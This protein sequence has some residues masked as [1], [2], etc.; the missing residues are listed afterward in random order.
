[1]CANVLPDAYQSSD[2][3]R[4]SLGFFIVAALDILGVLHNTNEQQAVI[5]NDEHQGWID[6]IYSCQVPDGSGFRGFPGTDLAERRS[7]DNQEWDPGNLPNTFFA[8]VTLLI[9]GDKLQRVKRDDLLTWLPGLQRSDG[10]FGELM[11]SSGIEG[12]RDLR[13]CCCAAGI[14]YILQGSHDDPRHKSINQNTLIDYILNSQHE[15]GGFA[16]SPFREPHSGLSYCAVA[17][18]ELIGRSAGPGSVRARK[19][20]SE[21]HASCVRWILQRQTTVLQDE[22]YDE[23]SDPDDESEK[24]DRSSNHPFS[25]SA[26]FYTEPTLVLGFNGRDNKIADTCY[27]FWNSGALSVGMM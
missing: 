14:A 24:H 3:S 5:S 11:S 7:V 23:D 12:G 18:L 22:Q 6:W 9:L 1:M 10:S 4:M 16:E 26:I 15:N 17:T 20:L 13:Y 27:C 8:L 2:A 19:V 25:S 21:D